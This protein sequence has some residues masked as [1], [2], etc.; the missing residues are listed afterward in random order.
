MQAEES[1]FKMCSC[2]YECPTCD[3]CCAR[4]AAVKCCNTVAVRAVVRSKQRI[5]CKYWS[6]SDRTDPSSRQYTAF[7]YPQTYYISKMEEF[8]EQ[9][10]ECIA[11]LSP[12]K[13]GDKTDRSN[14]RRLSLLSTAYKTSSNILLSML[15][16]YIDE[17]FG[18]HQFGFRRN[19]STTKV[20]CPAARHGGVFF[21]VGGR[22]SSSFLTSAL[23]GGEWSA[24]RPGRALPP[25]KRPPVPI[26]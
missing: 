21:G 20:S 9:W 1:G 18:D 13:K 2:M 22:Y 12:Y 16:P 7:W 26:P 19:K 15:T 24:S 10:K 8:P 6:N 17:I 11:G 23:D 25:G 3:K 14:Y 5:H 4:T